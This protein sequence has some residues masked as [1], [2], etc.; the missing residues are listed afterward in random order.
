M[1]AAARNN[2]SDDDFELDSELEDDLTLD[3]IEISELDAEYKS[4]ISG[5]ALYHLIS[6]YGADVTDILLQKFA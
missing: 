6:G 1:A 5:N 4:S 3:N 2:G